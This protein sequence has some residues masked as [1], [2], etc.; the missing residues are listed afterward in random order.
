MKK[1]NEV[2]K[3]IVAKE[4]QI[5]SLTMFEELDT[6]IGT[7]FSLHFAVFLIPNFE[8]LLLDTIWFKVAHW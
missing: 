3:F 1:L 2:M 4:N 5:G 8:V 7:C 6:D